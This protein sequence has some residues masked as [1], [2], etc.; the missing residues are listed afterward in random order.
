VGKKE[1][2]FDEADKREDLGR[3]G[4][5]FSLLFRLDEVV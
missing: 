2:A 1:G 4:C 3:F 5:R